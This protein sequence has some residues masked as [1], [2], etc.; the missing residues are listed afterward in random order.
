MTRFRDIRIL[1]PLLAWALAYGSVQIW[2]V[3]NGPGTALGAFT[4]A[5]ATALC[6]AAAVAGLWQHRS[7]TPA[8]ITLGATA[9]V[10]L[11]VAPYRL[12]LDLFGLV[13]SGS[14]I[15]FSAAPFASRVGCL[16]GAALLAVSTV[17]AVR[18]RSSGAAPAVALERPPRW[19]WASAYLVVAAF[20]VRMVWQAGFESSPPSGSSITFADAPLTGALT[21]LPFAAAGLL[22]PLALVHS[23]GRV[24]PRWVPVAAGRRVPRPLLLAPAALASVLI[25]AYFA[26]GTVALAATALRLVPGD[27]AEAARI[28]AG[29]WLADL[30]YVAWGT[31][32]AAAAVGYHRVTREGATPRTIMSS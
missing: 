24:F 17:A 32:L 26:S 27:A 31:G 2:S 14:G 11:A 15:A 30:A 19:A 1:V 4:G 25:L 12:V 18:R 22:L 28:L 6:A 29:T 20:A 3:V 16:T 13:Y 9:T 23:W 10:L 21:M 5:P 7:P 8:S